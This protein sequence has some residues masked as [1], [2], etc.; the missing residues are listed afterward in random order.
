MRSPARLLL[1]TLTVSLLSG[2]VPRAAEGAGPPAPPPAAVEACSGK[3]AN[4]A[5]TFEGRGHSVDGTCR[6]GPY[7]ATLAC[8]PAH[9][10]GPPPEAVQACS[11]KTENDACSVQFGKETVDGMCAKGPDGNAA[12][13]CRPAH[14]PGPPS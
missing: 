7:E 2:G 14:L 10:P 4:D 13:A 3:A 12:L 1:A 11:G 9:P 5:C 8:F 6:A